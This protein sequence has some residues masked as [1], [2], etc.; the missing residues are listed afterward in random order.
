MKD[1]RQ[2]EG[3]NARKRMRSA[4]KR[5]LT[6]WAKA[7]GTMEG[8]IEAG[9]WTGAAVAS[10]ELRGLGLAITSALRTAGATDATA[11][12]A[13]DAFDALREHRRINTKQQIEQVGPW[14][15]SPTTATGAV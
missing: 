9:E 7:V 15:V 3:E 12:K 14:V 8:V 2:T 1:R 13:Y 5:A 10:S 4:M 11:R 6:E